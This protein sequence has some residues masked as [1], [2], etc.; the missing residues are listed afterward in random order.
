MKKILSSIVAISLLFYALQSCNHSPSNNQAAVTSVD[1]TGIPGDTVAAD[2]IGTSSWTLTVV[3]KTSKAAVISDAS[4]SLPCA[5][6]TKNTGPD[7]RVTFSGLGNCPCQERG[8]KA[9]ITK[10][11]QCTDVEVPI[12]N[13]CGNV[14]SGLCE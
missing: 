14:Y 13:G 10:V 7:G 1:S 9:Y 8:S 12:T 5:N 11:G 6:M 3:V 4:V 2:T